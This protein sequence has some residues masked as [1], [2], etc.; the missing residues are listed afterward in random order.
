M[1]LGLNPEGVYAFLTS[2][3]IAPEGGTIP[4]LVECYSTDTIAK[5][6]AVAAIPMLEEQ[7]AMDSIAE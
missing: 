4:R 7:L 5:T 6:A 2:K 1:L 3:L